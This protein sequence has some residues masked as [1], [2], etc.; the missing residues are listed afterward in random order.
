VTLV[1]RR[2]P[3]GQG[4]KL[5][6]AADEA[7]I[8]AA[9]RR[10]L[11]TAEEHGATLQGFARRL[12]LDPEQAEDGAQEVFLRL[13]RALLAGDEIVDA[14]AWSFRAIYRLAMDE[15]RLEIRV[16]GL[17][18]RLSGLIPSEPVAGPD[19]ATRLSIWAAVDRLPGR[20]R[21]VLY[22]RYRADMS[23]DEIAAL[24]GITAGGARAIA[25]MATDRLRMLIV[26][27]EDAR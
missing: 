3:R 7:R 15:H 2:T 18:E 24:L 4:A 13:Y 14:R 17:R 16:R 5:R 12:G 21:Q 26:A 10:V 11:A 22:L 23:F 6:V 20:Q 25:T 8:G 1:P 27:G 9:Q 19:H